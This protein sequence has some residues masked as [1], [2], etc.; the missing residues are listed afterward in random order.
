MRNEFKMND[1]RNI[2]AKHLARTNRKA[3]WGSLQTRRQ[4]RQVLPSSLHPLAPSKFQGPRNGWQVMCHS[5]GLRP[6]NREWT[7]S[8]SAFHPCSIF[9]TYAA[10]GVP[11]QHA[12]HHLR[13][14]STNATAQAESLLLPSP[15]PLPQFVEGCGR[16]I[17][18]PAWLS[19]R[20][21]SF[22]LAR[23]LHNLSFLRP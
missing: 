5:T 11:S 4:A 18:D 15:P 12:I 20:H 13:R 23:I 14:D 1:V 8:P 3:P 22:R 21:P 10:K 16:S 19:Q 9:N 2:I 7:D 6:S 17:C